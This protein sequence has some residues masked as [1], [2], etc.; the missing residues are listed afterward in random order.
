VLSI[1]TVLRPALAVLMLALLAA[2]GGAEEMPAV[3]QGVAAARA[4]TVEDI[5]PPP[6]LDAG[7]AAGGKGLYD[8]YCAACHGRAG[9]GFPNWKEPNADGSY[10]PPPHDATG[11]TW[12]H[13]DELLLDITANGGSLPESRMPAF[14]DKLTEDEIRAILE[15]IKTWWGPEERAFQW[16]VTWQARQ[17]KE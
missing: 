6:A 11:H 5:P 4:R 9:E 8:R 15:Y 14:G 17:V 7:L 1:Q 2:C 3:N 10:N 16:Q 12:H 13:A